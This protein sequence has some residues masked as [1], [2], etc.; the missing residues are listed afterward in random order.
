MDDSNILSRMERPAVDRLISLEPGKRARGLKAVSGSDSCFTGI[1]I[2]KRILPEVILLEALVQTGLAAI[3]SHEEY[4]TKE[5]RLA[6]V[7]NAKF[8]GKA[9]PGDVIILDAEIYKL[10]L[11]TGVCKIS[12][13]V[14]EKCICEATVI[15]GIA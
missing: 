14:D 1:P 5:V 15:Y 6:A 3:I 13:Y 7:E 9:F 2:D 12:A 11:S 8:T 10:R 4:C